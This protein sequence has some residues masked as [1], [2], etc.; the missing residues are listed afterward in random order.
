[1]MSENKKYATENKVVDDEIRF[2]DLLVA[3]ARQKR[4][5]LGFPLFFGV[6]ALVTVILMKPVFISTAV[7]MPPQQQNSGMAAM[8]GQLG[9]LAAAANIGGIKN[10]NDLYVGM[11]QSRTV[12]DRLIEKFKL[13]ERYKEETSDKTR[14]KL[15]RLSTIQS[16]KEGLITIMFEDTDPQVAAD[17]ANAYVSELSRLNQKLAVTEAAKRR[18]FFEAQLKDAKEQLALSEIAMR[19]TQEKTGM[20]QL[21]GQVKELIASTAHLQAQIAAKEVQL[22]AMRSFAT[23][24]NPEFMR[25]QQELNGLS[26][27]LSKIKNGKMT[28]DGNPLVPTGKIP[29]VGVEYIRALRDVKYNEA[30]FELLAKQFELAKIEEAKDSSLIQQLDKAMPAEQKAKPKRALTILIAVLIGLLFGIIFA[31]IKD[32]FTSAGNSGTSAWYEF[33]S[34]WKQKRS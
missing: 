18:V 12:A 11:L 17:I 16:G 3:I 21:E 30:I 20:L 19:N 29:A 1:M 13:Q 28:G 31:I 33:S 15:K 5:V 24:N 6:I 34:A 8:L 26:E 32:I 27:Q 22:T 25:L 9:G 14:E 2:V 7:I 4:I 23:P 10:P